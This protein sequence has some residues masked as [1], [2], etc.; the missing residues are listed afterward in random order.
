MNS[1]YKLFI[2]FTKNRASPYQLLSVMFIPSGS[3]REDFN[4]D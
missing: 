2:I 3:E 1:R 4:T